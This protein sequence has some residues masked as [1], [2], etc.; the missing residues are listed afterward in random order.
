[1]AINVF[2]FVLL[3]IVWYVSVPTYVKYV[4][5]HTYW[6]LMV[7]ATLHVSLKIVQYVLTIRSVPIVRVAIYRH[8]MVFRV[9]WPVD[10]FL[11]LLT[12]HAFRVRIFL[13]IARH[14]WV[15]PLHQ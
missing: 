10:H 1:M 8:L 2:L 11:S 9:I 12:I 5:T 14:V 15:Y 13:Q 3:A 6:V 4:S 7:L